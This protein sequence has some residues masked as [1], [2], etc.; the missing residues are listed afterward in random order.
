MQSKSIQ[1]QH[2]SSSIG[3]YVRVS[4][5]GQN[6]DG[7]IAEIDRWLQGHQYQNVNWFIDHSSGDNLVRP[8][9][10]SLQKSIFDGAIKTVIVWRLDRLSRNLR[11][12][13]NVLAD[14]CDRGLRVVSVTQQIDFNGATGK[15]LAAVLLGV[16]EMEQETRRER[17]AAGIA[18]AKDRGVYF[19]RMKGTTKAKP[20]RATELRE[21]GLTDGEIGKALG[22]SRRTV[23]RYL[24]TAIK[25]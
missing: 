6:T 18:A 7:Q 2:P 3:V 10:E 14:W 15:M 21:Q 16:A 17:Q 11:D 24:Q 23:Q 8:K 12:G 9:F 4:T 5:T 22:V 25:D 1:K 13:I 20:K 19:G